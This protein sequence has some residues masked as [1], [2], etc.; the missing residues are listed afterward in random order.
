[1]TIYINIWTVSSLFGSF[2]LL[3][4]SLVLSL[5]PVFVNHKPL[6]CTLSSC[7]TCAD[8]PP[9]SPHSLLPLFPTCSYVS[10]FGEK[11]PVIGTDGGGS[12]VHQ[13]SGLIDTLWLDI[14]S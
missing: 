12:S 6:Q 13:I 5:S 14:Q 2:S 3:D 4:V 1:M 11:D 7:H 9:S 8:Y 10:A